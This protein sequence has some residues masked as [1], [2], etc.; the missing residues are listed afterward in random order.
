MEANETG[1]H[2]EENDIKQQQRTKKRF[3]EE[4]RKGKKGL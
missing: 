2:N 3:K 1:I 4:K